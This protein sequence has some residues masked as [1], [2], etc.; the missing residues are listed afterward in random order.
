M[1]TA[2]ES[3]LYG[4]EPGCPV[5]GDELMRECGMCGTEFC[6]GCFPRSSVCPDCAEPSDEEDK[7]ADL[8]DLGDLDEI[9]DEEE[10]PADEEE[11]LFEDGLDDET[12]DRDY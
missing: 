8:E 1:A 2:E 10:E 6:R 12:E 9:F 11:P 3:P 7:D 4:V 5:H